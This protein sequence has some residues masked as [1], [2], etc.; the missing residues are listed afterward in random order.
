MGICIRVL[1]VFI[2]ERQSLEIYERAEWVRAGDDGWTPGVRMW[3]VLEEMRY[4]AELSIGFQFMPMYIHTPRVRN[5]WNG[6]LLLV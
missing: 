2:Q 1:L 5:V 3:G 4:Y 6:S